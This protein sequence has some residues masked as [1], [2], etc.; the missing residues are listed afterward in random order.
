MYRVDADC[1]TR[2]VSDQ[3]VVP[4]M[5][6]WEIVRKDVDTVRT[7]TTLTTT[8]LY[9]NLCFSLVHPHYLDIHNSLGS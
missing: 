3:C 4:V 8:D 9:L 6:D 2:L 7:L 1:R 5:S